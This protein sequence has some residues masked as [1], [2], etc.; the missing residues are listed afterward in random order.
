[1]LELSSKT[2]ASALVRLEAADTKI[3][4]DLTPLATLK[5]ADLICHL[6]QRYASTALLPLSGSSVPL[7]R[8]MVTSNSHN[9]V[10]M[11]GKVNALIQRAIDN[12]M[13]YLTFLL[14]KQKKNDYK[15]KD[16]EL[17]FARNNTEPC[18]MSCE[19]LETVREAVK[20]GLSGK[21]AE[22]FLA[23]VGMA[24]HRCVPCPLV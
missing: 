9:I 10:R 19:F 14:T 23:E 6:A 4:P 13:S 17:S 18:K 8:E 22:A 1:V 3:E 12:I 16:D 24:F 20:E 5:P 15:P 11:E 21:N 2:N 7:R